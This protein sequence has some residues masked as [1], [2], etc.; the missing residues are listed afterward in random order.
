MFLPIVGPLCLYHEGN[1]SLEE[2]TEEG[3]GS[4]ATDDPSDH[5]KHFSDVTA[6]RACVVSVLI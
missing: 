6:G 1:E 4:P 2:E 5:E 3:E